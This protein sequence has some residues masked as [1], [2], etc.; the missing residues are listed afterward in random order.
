MVRPIIW[1]AVNWSDGAAEQ[2]IAAIDAI[3]A[4]G[5]ETNGKHSQ[6]I[7]SVELISIPTLFARP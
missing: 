5:S 6:R 1:P 3:I 4:I 2:P 7:A